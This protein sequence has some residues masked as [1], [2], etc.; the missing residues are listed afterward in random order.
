MT[1][2]FAFSVKLGF[3]LFFSSLLKVL[4][5]LFTLN[6]LLMDLCFSFARFYIR[7]YVVLYT[8]LEKN[9]YLSVIPV[10][11]RWIIF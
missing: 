9:I 5:F 8:F 2:G 3:V 4:Y 1:L 6:Y 10:A 11:L 7:F